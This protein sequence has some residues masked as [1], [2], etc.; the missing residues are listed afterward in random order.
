MYVTIRVGYER[1]SS[2]KKA[3]NIQT[4]TQNTP[5]TRKRYD[6]LPGYLKSSLVQR[7]PPRPGMRSFNICSVLEQKLYN[8]YMSVFNSFKQK[9]KTTKKKSPY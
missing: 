2:D 8:L 6:T 3:K 1:K 9:S 5:V 4:T 7:I